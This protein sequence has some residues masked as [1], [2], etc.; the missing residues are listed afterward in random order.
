MEENGREA[1]M[2][3]QRYERA[4]SKIKHTYCAIRKNKQAPNSIQK[5]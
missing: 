4:T 2:I 5:Y 3:L 1:K